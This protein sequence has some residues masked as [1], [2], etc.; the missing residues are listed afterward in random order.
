MCGDFAVTNSSVALMLLLRFAVTLRSGVPLGGLTDKEFQ[1]LLGYIIISFAFLDPLTRYI[2]VSESFPLRVNAIF[3]FFLPS[4]TYFFTFSILGFDPVELQFFGVVLS[5]PFSF[6]VINAISV[7][8]AYM[9][10]WILT[11]SK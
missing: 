11:H 10:W 4:I 2:A 5:F 9:I 7:F 3:S 6:S 1:L 8:A